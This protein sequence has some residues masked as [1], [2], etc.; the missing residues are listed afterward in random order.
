MK[1]INN[2]YD[3][4]HSE[5]LNEFGKNLKKAYKEFQH[6]IKL[7]REDVSKIDFNDSE[8]IITGISELRT[9]RDTMDK[10]ENSV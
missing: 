6:E 5:I 9:A 2:K 7:K 1:K 4:L 8:N 3:A 10:Y